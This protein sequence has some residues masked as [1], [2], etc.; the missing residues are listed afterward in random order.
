MTTTQK[1]T[2]ASTIIGLDYVNL[3][4]DD[5]DESLERA[6]DFYQDLLGLKPLERPANTDSGRTGAWFQCG[7]QQLH[8][9]IENGASEVNRLSRRHPAFRVSDLEALRA[10]RQDAGVE[11]IPGNKFPGQKRFFVRDPWNNRL[12]FVER[13]AK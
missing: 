1:S 5:R 7:S 12:E 11:I 3:L 8:L 9:T 10:R 6:R 2:A 4:I 13:I